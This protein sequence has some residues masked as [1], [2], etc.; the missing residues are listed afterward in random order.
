M[1]PTEA[2]PF[3]RRNST[4]ESRRRFARAFST[5]SNSTTL[6]FIVQQYTSYLLIQ[7]NK[8]IIPLR[9]GIL[10][11]FCYPRV[12][13]GGS[14]NGRTPPFGGG[15]DGPNPSPPASRCMKRVVIKIGTKVL[16]KEDGT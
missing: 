4:I 1:S 11:D 14:S 8:Q 5:R 9:C 3:L 10:R 2:A 7:L 15:Y 16:S 12:D 6:P 13:I